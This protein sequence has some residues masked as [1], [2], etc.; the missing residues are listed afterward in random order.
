M[1][2]T[3]THILRTC[4]HDNHIQLLYH[5]GNLILADCSEDR[6]IDSRDYVRPVEAPCAEISDAG[7]GTA[8]ATTAFHERRVVTRQLQQAMIPGPELVQ[9]QVLGRA[10]GFVSPSTP[11]VPNQVGL[12]G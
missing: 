2:G 10:A 6:V 11:L 7:T 9:V 12:L 5:R 3:H 4:F 1:H 8:T